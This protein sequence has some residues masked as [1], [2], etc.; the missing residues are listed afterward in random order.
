M[1]WDFWA[2]FSVRETKPSEQ[3]PGCSQVLCTATI[4]RA[5]SCLVTGCEVTPVIQGIM[6]AT[7]ELYLSATAVHQ[8]HN[9]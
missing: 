9:S 1:I 7:T 2:L 6:G 5:G 3:G 4:E 8:R